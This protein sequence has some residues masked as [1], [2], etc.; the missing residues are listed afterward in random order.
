[1]DFIDGFMEYTEGVT[2]PKNFL[3][4]TAITSIAGALERRVFTIT[5]GKPA[6]PNLITW[7]VGPPGSGKSEAI[8]VAVE[9]MDL[10]GGFNLAANNMTK[11]ALIDALQEAE[12]QVFIDEKTMLDYHSLFVPAPE[13]GVLVPAHDLEFLSVINY[14]WDNPPFYRE[15]RRGMKTETNPTGEVDIARPQLTIL[16]GTQP[17]YLS[18]LL[19]DEAWTMGTMSRTIMIYSGEAPPPDLFGDRSK[20]ESLKTKLI[21]EFRRMARLLGTVTWAPEAKSAILNWQRAG[22]EPVPSHSK[23]TNYNSRRLFNTIKLAIIS[24]ASRGDDL[25][26]TGF[27]VERA[28]TWLL[29]AESVMPDVFRAMANKSDKQ[30]IDELYY[31]CWQQYAKAKK[32]VSEVAIKYFLMSRV[33]SDKIPHIIAVSCQTGML[34]DRGQGLYEPTPQNMHGV[35]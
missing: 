30:I 12:R 9:L 6:Y 4:W 34:V 3:L 25:V 2:S 14:I 28:L 16:A 35:E 15:K 18:G 5:A 32:L 13:L 22:L 26:I 33:P 7:L 23:L 24:S 10:A 20:N 27:D 19:P 21:L 31:F 11:A 1:M 17:G 8:G 29:E